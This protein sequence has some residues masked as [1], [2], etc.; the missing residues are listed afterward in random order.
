MIVGRDPNALL[1]FRQAVAREYE[2][3]GLA[4]LTYGSV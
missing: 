3:S 2:Q 4:H 1:A